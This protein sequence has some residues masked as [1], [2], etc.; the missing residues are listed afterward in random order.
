MPPEV[1]PPTLS[2]TVLVHGDDRRGS[3]SVAPAINVSTSKQASC[4]SLSS[5]SLTDSY[6][7]LAHK[8]PEGAGHAD[9]LDALNPERHVYSRYSA[10]AVIRAE[11]VLSK[12]TVRSRS[13]LC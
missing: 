12:I 1:R 3:S 5:N 11:Q 9:S 8:I 4:S 2:G 13:Y 6:S 7:T 10:D